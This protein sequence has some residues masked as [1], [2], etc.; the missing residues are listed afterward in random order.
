[1]PSFFFSNRLLTVFNPSRPKMNIIS[2]TACAKIRTT[3][4]KKYLIL[5]I[6]STNWPWNY[7]SICKPEFFFEKYFPVFFFLPSGNYR[8]YVCFDLTLKS[9]LTKP[10]ENGVL[11][12]YLGTNCSVLAFRLNR[13]EN[14]LH[15]LL[16]I[17]P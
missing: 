15:V 9:D 13:A 7:F 17:N 10:T 16:R 2:P 8:S 11:L 14:C 4:P 5:K 12:P 1:M 6:N 3:L